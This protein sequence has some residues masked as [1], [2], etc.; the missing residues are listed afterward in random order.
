[1]AIVPIPNQPINIEPY[2]PDPCR[3]NYGGYCQKVAFS[4]NLNFQFQQTPCDADLVTD[5]NFNAVGSELLTN[6]GFTGSATGW[7][8]GA[9]WAYGSNK[10]NCT[11]GSS[12]GFTQSGL[13]ITATQ[14]YKV[15]VITSGRTAGYLQCVLGGVTGP[16]MEGN[17]IYTFYITAS[18]STSNI[19]FTNDTLYDGSVDS[20]SLKRLVPDWSADACWQYE[21]T[22]AADTDGMYT[23]VPGTGGDLTQT[24]SYANGGYYYV[25]FS[26]SNR[27]A[28][29]VRVTMGGTVIDDI[30]ENGTFTLYGTSIGTNKLK[31]GADASFDGSI[32]YVTSYK[33]VAAFIYQLLNQDGTVASTQPA[34]WNESTYGDKVLVDVE[35]SGVPEGC[36]KVSV[37]NPCDLS[38]GAELLTN[39]SFAS[40]ASWTHANE[41]GDD[42]GLQNV[43]ISGGA[44]AMTVDTTNRAIAESYKQA[45]TGKT[46]GWYRISFTTGHV[47][48]AIVSQSGP[49]Y[50]QVIFGSAYHYVPIQDLVANTEYAAFFNVNSL[51]GT[52][53]N[54]TVLVSMT[55]TSSLAGGEYFEITDVSL[56]TATGS[57]WISNCINITEDFDCE[58]A[59]IGTCETGTTNLGFYWDGTF[60]LK[61]RLPFLYFNPTYPIEASDYEYS[62]GRRAITSASREKYYEGHVD[63][64]DETAHDT[65][66]TQILCDT[67]T[68]DGVEYFVKPEDYKPEWIEKN[69]GLLT[70]QARIA[71]RKKTST[72]FKK[73]I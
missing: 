30:S 55:S 50:V 49:N 60:K 20:V 35:L 70:A 12:A 67:F 72:I 25:T 73:N 51:L 29:R 57:E 64:V 19:Q 38:A 56:R 46:D 4:D 48:A 8:L 44:I 2:V 66:S 23:A 16:A 42:T 27:T 17:D 37:G 39:A 58:K 68:V 5:G 28:G 24:I 21:T 26:V 59:I 14:T 15:T 63:H 45:L 7:T 11:P 65:L 34:A 10:I 1:M 47:D 3:T 52:T 43:V 22:G 62:S 71:M 9:G 31:F 53:D 32:S 69:G 40:G 61:Q 13:T 6:G 33:L 54:Y 18:S 41:A 36:Y